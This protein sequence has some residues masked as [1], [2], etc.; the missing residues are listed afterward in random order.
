MSS[1]YT[2]APSGQGWYPDPYDATMLRW[3]NGFEW[4]HETMT[5]SVYLTDSTPL[6][7]VV[8]RQRRS[9]KSRNRPLMLLAA[10]VGGIIVLLTTFALAPGQDVDV[11][12]PAPEPTAP[13]RPQAEDTE[14]SVSPPGTSRTYN[15][16]V[17]VHQ[18][19]SDTEIGVGTAVAISATELLTANHVVDQSDTAEIVLPGG[20]TMTVTVV[21]RDP[22]RDLALIETSRSHGLGAA[23]IADRDPRIGD[24]VHAFGSPN[25]YVQVS[26]GL[27]TG[28][29]DGD[30]NGVEDVETDTAVRHGN[31][32]GPLVNSD[33]EVVGIVSY[34]LG[35]ERYGYAICVDEIRAFLGQR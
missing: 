14:P 23:R 21:R 25:D 32:G 12:L 5:N 22:L 15:A 28:V 8:A 17:V 10:G 3:W 27:V 11:A 34:G 1:Y 20:S 6:A 4:T 18:Q 35:D 9:A 13:A 33:D 2:T 26:S 16:T 7:P 24:E 30:G 31:S 19:I 29:F